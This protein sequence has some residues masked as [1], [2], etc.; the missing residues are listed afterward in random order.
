[1]FLTSV[2]FRGVGEGA[3]LEYYSAGSTYRVSQKIFTPL[4]GWGITSMQPIFK[5]GM[6]IYQ[7]VN[8]L[9]A[10]FLLLHAGYQSKANLD[11]KILFGKS[12]IIRTRRLEK[13]LEGECIGTRIPHSILN[14]EFLATAIKIRF[15][16][17]KISLHVDFNI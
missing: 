15:L 11:E 14:Q 17:Q 12:L 13:C 8:S 5:I 6:L 7:P 16:K 3:S 1:M 4:A 10:V 9:R 2:T